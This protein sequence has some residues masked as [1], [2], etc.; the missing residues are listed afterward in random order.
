L[1][2]MVGIVSTFSPSSSTIMISFSL[3]SNMVCIFLLSSIKRIYPHFRHFN[4]PPDDINILL[5]SGQ[6]IGIACASKGD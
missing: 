3:R 6:N 5:H 2:W 4:W 1:I